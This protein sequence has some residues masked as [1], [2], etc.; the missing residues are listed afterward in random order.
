MKFISGLVSISFRKLSSDEIIDITKNANLSAIEWGGDVHVPAGKTDIAAA[1]G[2]K[3]SQA[4]LLIPEYGSY[5]RLGVSE[6]EEIDGVAVCARAL[7]TDTVRIWAH[8]KGSEAATE[9]EYSRAVQDAKRICARYPDLTFCTECHNYTLTDDYKSNLRLIEDVNMPN[10][11]AFWQPNQFKSFEYNLESARALAPFVKSVHVF[12]WEG[13]TA[14]PLAYHDEKW[15]KYLSVFAERGSSDRIYA[16]L[17]FMHDGSPGS[18][19][20]T[21]EELRSILQF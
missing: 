9:E 17:E 16:M 14:Y 6:P 5:Y 19:C 18:L 12:S 7:K 10:F 3:T 13:K 11:G 2:A 4:G 8:N 1:V 21:A 15:K 20:K